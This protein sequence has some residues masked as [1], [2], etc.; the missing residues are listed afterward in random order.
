MLRWIRT[1]NW[2][3]YVFANLLCALSIYQGRPDPDWIII[4]MLAG[5]PLMAYWLVESALDLSAQ[6]DDAL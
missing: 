3:C 2:Y 1:V 4:V 5:N 6:R